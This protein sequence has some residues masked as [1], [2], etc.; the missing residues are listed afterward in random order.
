MIVMGS[1]VCGLCSQNPLITDYGS[2]WDVGYKRTL[3]T[4]PVLYYLME[5]YKHQREVYQ[6]GEMYS[7][8]D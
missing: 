6:H 2:K 5:V 4:G 3:K 8:V 1:L 7:P